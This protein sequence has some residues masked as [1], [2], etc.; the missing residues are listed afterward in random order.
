M[1]SGIGRAIGSQNTKSEI[2]IQ[3]NNQISW[4]FY[5]FIMGPKGTNNESCL[6]KGIFHG[7]FRKIETEE[8]GPIEAET[9]ST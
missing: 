9:G 8:P 5:R 7:L 2:P 1:E 4:T 6:F 3:I